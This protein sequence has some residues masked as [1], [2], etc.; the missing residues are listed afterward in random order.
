MAGV[1]LDRAG[2]EDV[3]VLTSE[4]SVGLHGLLQG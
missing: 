2:L 4:N 1:A 3:G